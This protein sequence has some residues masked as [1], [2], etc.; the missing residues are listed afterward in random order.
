LL[1]KVVS[2]EA[3]SVGILGIRVAPVANVVG[4]LLLFAV[5]VAPVGNP[6]VV[7]LDGCVLPTVGELFETGN[8]SSS[9]DAP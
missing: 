2:G 6:L 4:V 5:L 3:G 7:V 1:L 8:S 9:S